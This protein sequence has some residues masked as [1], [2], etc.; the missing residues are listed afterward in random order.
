MKGGREGLVTVTVSLYIAMPLTWAS[1]QKKGA[2]LFPAVRATSLSI[3][4]PTQVRQSDG[5]IFIITRVYTAVKVYTA[6][7]PLS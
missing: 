4:T 7:Y 2:G 3:T 1:G 6:G 5:P